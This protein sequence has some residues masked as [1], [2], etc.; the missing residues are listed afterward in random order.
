M[1]PTV[2]SKPTLRLLQKHKVI[3]A[4]SSKW[5]Q[6]GIVLFE[7]DKAY[8]LATIKAN[9]NNVTDR[10]YEMFGYWIQI[11]PNASWDQLVEAL[12]E[13]GVEMNGLAEMVMEKFIGK[14]V[15]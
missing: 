6:L 4:V 2:V 7:D 5:Y 8:Q 13:P 1:Y 14:Y 10:C 9:N 3:T 15:Q 11:Q 12:R